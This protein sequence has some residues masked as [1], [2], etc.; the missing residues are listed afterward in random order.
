MDWNDSP[1]VR[2]GRDGEWF[3]L[4]RDPSATPAL[5]LYG[6]MGLGLP[7]ANISKSERLTSDGS[8]VR[9]VRYEDREVFIPL[10]LEADSVHEL[11]TIRQRMF[12]LMA[13]DLGPVEVQ[14]EIPQGP[15]QE[16]NFRSIYGYLV[17]G[18]D[19]DF[20]KEYG[21]VWQTL[22]LVFDC[23]DPWW[24]GPE[25][26]QTL[27]LNPGSKPFLS[28]TIP[29]F[30]V[31]LSSSSV[32]GEWNIAIEGDGDVWP[33]WEII[34]P[35]RDLIIKRGNKRIFIQGDFRDD[36]ITRIET[37]DARITPNRW[38]DVSLDSRLF[39]L[40]RG[41][42]KLSITMVGSN[43]E[44]MVRLTWRERYRGAL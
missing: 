12:R 2:I 31:V 6:S 39:P 30:P 4:G 33:T 17:E 28:D 35:G 7:L 8:V 9:G 40:S 37:E 16:P 23:P 38:A 44:T 13:P 10:L 25:R 1:I 42:N 11:N 27:Q 29:F 14:L 21:G 32:A 15:D 19:G 22:G 43:E 3:E 26:T 41:P 20:S 18:L 24:L 34:G 5:H 36:T